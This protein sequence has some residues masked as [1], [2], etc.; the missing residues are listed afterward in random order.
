MSESDIIR[1]LSVTIGALM[2][3]ILM[4]GRWIRVQSD[5]IKLLIKQ[6]SAASGRANN[7]QLEN[8]KLMEDH[9][10]AIADSSV[11]HR[12]FNGANK[13][14]EVLKGVMKEIYDLADRSMVRTPYKCVGCGDAVADSGSFCTPCLN[15]RMN[16]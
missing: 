3:I 5:R 7:Y 13:E 4:A 16:R 1:V 6:K 11:A 9:D 8:M 10:R 14:R 15:E 12:R 2:M